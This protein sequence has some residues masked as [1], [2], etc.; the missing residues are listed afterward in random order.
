MVNFSRFIELYEK[1]VLLNKLDFVM[2]FKVVITY[3][4]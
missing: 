1:Y 4:K 3:M 2:N